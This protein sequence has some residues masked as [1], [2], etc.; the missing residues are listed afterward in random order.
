MAKSGS[1][2]KVKSTG[3]KQH[4]PSKSTKKSDYYSGAE[5][6]ARTCPKCGPGVFMAEHKDRYH[7]GKCSYMEKK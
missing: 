2:R 5:R 7:C 6:K 4:K 3:K 1:K